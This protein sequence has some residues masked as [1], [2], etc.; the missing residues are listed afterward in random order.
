MPGPGRARLAPML[1]PSGRLLGDLTL[2]NWD[3]ARFW[4]MG[5][6]YLRAWH[7]RWFER[8]LPEIGVTV[9]DISDEVT[10]IAIAGPRSRELLARLTPAD[11]S[12][13]AFPFMAA[14]AIDVGLTQAWVGRLSVTG[15]LGYEINVPAA[16]QRV[17]YDA[18]REV[19]R[20]LGL[21]PIGYAAVNALR[22][23]KSFGIWSREFTWAY[24]PGMSGLDRFVAFEKPAF[25]GRDAALRERDAGAAQRLVTLE[26]DAGDSDGS[27]FE[28]VWDGGRRVGFVTSGGFGPTIGKSLAMAY[29]SRELTAPS[30][31]LD[32]HIVGERRAARVIAASPVD[33]A[34]TRLRG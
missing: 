1:S 11:L 31:A 24:T 17:L 21:K 7:M 23:E 19:G 32:V 2:F 29:V 33:P 15:E 27:G 28:P 4:I 9:R 13:A 8:Q 20:D 3:D 14:R 18:L 10:G 22:L 26:V 30:T 5:S 12:A 25:L 16:E 34:G 6:Y